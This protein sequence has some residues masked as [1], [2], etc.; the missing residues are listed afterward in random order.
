[1]TRFRATLTYDG[2]AYH[3]F[4]RQAGETPTIQR[5]VERAIGDVTGQVATVVGAGRTDSGVHATGQV[6]AFDVDWQHEDGDL[7]RALNALLPDDIALQDISRQEGFHPRFD[8][9]SRVYRYVVIVAKHRQPLLRYRAWHIPTTLDGEAMQNAAQLLVGDHDF[10]A[11]GKPPQGESTVRTVLNSD[12][13]VTLATD[14]QRFET[15]TY[16]IEANA[17][18]KQMVRRI[19]GS[20]VDVGRGRWTVDVFRKAFERARLVE[21]G[22]IAPPDG[23]TLLKVCYPETVA[24]GT[25]EAAK[26]PAGGTNHG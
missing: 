3:G 23:L 12:W 9:V 11:F 21:K 17:F 7:L 18:L 4:Q 6:I 10:A 16:T 22:T 5:A 8:A 15:W 14:E 24:E 26:M 1:M 20:L 25:D 19:V 2:T 13:Q